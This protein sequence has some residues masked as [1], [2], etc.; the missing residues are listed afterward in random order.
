MAT[1][2]SGK[3]TYEVIEDWAKLPPGWS[4]GKVASVA[5]DSQDRVYA[6]QRK[7]PPVIVFDREGNFLNSWGTGAITD[8]HGIYIGPDDVMYVTDQNDHLAMKF[9]LDGNLISVLGS[10]GQHSDTGC[11]EGGGTVLR[12]GG[13]FN[14]PTEMVPSPSGDLYVSDGYRNCRIHRFSPDG[15]LKSSWGLPGKS[16]GGEFHLPHSVWVDREGLVYVC[17]RENSRVQ[18]F[19]P[20]GDFIAQWTDMLK[21]CD[22][23][24]DAGETAFV[25]EVAQRVSVWDKDGNLLERLEMPF[26]HGLF[27]D[28]KGDLYL[29]HSPGQN[30]S[31]LV[32][33]P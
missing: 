3:F 31:K 28:S 11:D 32:K 30:V 22:L 14:G 27:G 8:P 18:V 12:P 2:G 15:T 17:D 1:V 33:V 13:P 21:P 9:T 16:A 5:V 24:M 23:Y 25:S 20:D 26:A 7:D 10:R 6:F 4:F 19:S 29:A